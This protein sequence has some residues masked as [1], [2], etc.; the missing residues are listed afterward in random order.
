MASLI[1]WSRAFPASPPQIP[2]ARRFLATIVEGWP[3]ADDVLLCL[4]E[5]ATNAVL[6]S[7]SREPGGCFSIHVQ[8][9]RNH[10]RVEVC[11][12]GGP[13]TSRALTDLGQQHGR[14]LDIVDQL[15]RSWG[16]SGD[17]SGWTLWFEIGQG[18]AQRWVTA[19]DGQ[20]LRQLRR[21]HGLTQAELAAKAGVSR[22]TVGRLEGS[23]CAACRR[24][25]LARLAAALGAEP[26]ALAPRPTSSQQA[27]GPEPGT[28]C[29]NPSSAATGASPQRCE[30]GCDPRR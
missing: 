19:L 13:W 14:G 7:R 10:L 6:H 27:T 28:A 21:D 15:A 8:L 1:A 4:S 17:E 5:L 16:R 25:T 11:D 26:S 18:S 12:Q 29:M 3:V 24:R 9:H 22:A 23:T 2:E 30:T 20:R